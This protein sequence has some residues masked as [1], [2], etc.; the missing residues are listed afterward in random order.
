M[1]EDRIRELEQTIKEL[2][3]RAEKAEEMVQ[4]LEKIIKHQNRQGS[5]GEAVAVTADGKVYIGSAMPYVNERQEI[6]DR[7]GNSSF[8]GTDID[9]IL[10]ILDDVLGRN[11]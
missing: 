4:I 6:T 11:R 5:I 7:L 3:A 10:K 8:N 9:T 2:R 1:S